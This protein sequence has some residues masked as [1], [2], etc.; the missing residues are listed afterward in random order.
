MLVASSVL[1][2]AITAVIYIGTARTASPE[3]YGPTVAAIA[4]GIAAVGFFDLGTNSLWV[5]EIARSSM[6]M[7]ELGR[8]TISKLA[9]ATV[10]ALLWVVVAFCFLGGTPYWVA[11]PVAVATLA[12]QTLQVALRGRAMIERVALA[13]LLDRVVVVVL[14]G[15]LALLGLEPVT[16]LWLV[17]CIGPLVSAALG[18]FF[19]PAHTR[20][21]LIHSRPMNPWT[22]SRYYGLSAL[23]VGSQ[24]LDL[25]I[26][27]AMGGPVAA[28]LYGAV[29]RFTQPMGML[30]NSF[31]SASVP[32]VA[33]AKSWGEAWSHARKASWLLIVAVF[34]CLFVAA[35]APLIVDILI[36]D[37]YQGATPVL[38]ILALGTIPAIFNQPLAAFLQAM[39]FDRVVSLITVSAVIVQLVSVAI[40][41]SHLGAVGAA[42]G[43][44]S[45]QV[46]IFISLGVVLIRVLRLQQ[47]KE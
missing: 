27:N 33:R 23:A 46:L 2:Q 43:F 20:I 45:L 44:L 25:P 6:D 28:G 15:S 12:S 14:L 37:E 9:F 19:T 16:V 7:R 29:N 11:G 21:K 38:Q 17:L 4:L 26:M 31:A 1:A 32:H 3:V 13:V 5:R 36:G 24:S 35:T 8:R 42:I 10:V 22:G 18:Y 40:L 30:A 47:K 39:R 41:A 34:G